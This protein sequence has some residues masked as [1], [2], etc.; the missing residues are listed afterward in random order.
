MENKPVVLML[1]CVLYTVR[2]ELPDV[3]NIFVS[4]INLSVKTD[5]PPELD[6]N[7]LR[8][9]CVKNSK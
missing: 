3:Q 6:M 1:L 4:A 7:I 5:E 2:S 9:V 8:P